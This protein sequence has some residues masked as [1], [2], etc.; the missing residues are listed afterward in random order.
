M[1]NK[2][3]KMAGFGKKFNIFLQVESKVQAARRN[4]NI[5]Q[6]GMGNGGRSWEKMST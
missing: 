6:G 2:V 4:I 1:L 5:E 3:K